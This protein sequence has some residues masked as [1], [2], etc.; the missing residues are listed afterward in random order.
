[1]I[2]TVIKFFFIILILYMYCVHARMYVVYVCVSV[3]VLHRGLS[4]IIHEKNISKSSMSDKEKSS[5]RS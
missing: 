4:M 5:E 3:C 1:M 2:Y